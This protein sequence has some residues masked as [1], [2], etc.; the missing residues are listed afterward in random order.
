MNPTSSAAPS[1]PAAAG[2]TLSFP[3]VQQAVLDEATLDALF[4]DLAECTQVLAVVPK[5]AA[6]AMAAD[7][8]I[9]LADA[10]PALR[11]GALRGVQVRYRWE[12]KEWCDTL[13]ATPAGVRLVRICSDDV[14]ASAQ[15]GSS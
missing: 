13:L 7:R 8:A 6:Q 5:D 15:P 12:R 14:L 3:P 10:L 2:A 1:A 11:A 4:R 9:G